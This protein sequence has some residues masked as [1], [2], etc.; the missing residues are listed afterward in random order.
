[1]VK[2]SNLTV[3]RAISQMVPA[4]VFFYSL[5]QKRNTGLAKYRPFSIP[6]LGQ[7]PYKARS[8]KPSHEGKVHVNQLNSQ[9]ESPLP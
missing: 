2:P 6:A 4:K 7:I 3:S 9:P 5:K 1:M 8:N